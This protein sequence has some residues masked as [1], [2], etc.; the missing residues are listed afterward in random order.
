MLVADTSDNILFCIATHARRHGDGENLQPEVLD[1]LK[2]VKKRKKAV[3]YDKERLELT[4]EGSEDL[5]YA[6]PLA[7][8]PLN[9]SDD[10]SSNEE[11][12]DKYNMPNRNES[13]W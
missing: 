9:R 6:G 5:P 12:P 11:D 2:A 13:D 8:S 3:T 4:R 7:D 10:D 1:L